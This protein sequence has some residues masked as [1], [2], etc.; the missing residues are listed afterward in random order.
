MFEA[1][2]RGGIT[3]TGTQKFAI[4]FECALDV[5]EKL[6]LLAHSTRG[7][8]VATGVKGF[9]E[10]LDANSFYPWA[11]KQKLPVGN[12]RFIAP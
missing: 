10:Y 7:S 8:R 11:M 3:G 4:S 12:F 6:V 9:I 2:K 1:A 5:L